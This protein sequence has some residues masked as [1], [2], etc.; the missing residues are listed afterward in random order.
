MHAVTQANGQ[1]YHYDTY[2]N[3]IQRGSDTVD[4]DVFN[5]PTRIGNHHFTYGPDRA[6]YKQVGPTG[7]T[8]YIGNYEEVI[9]T[10]GTEQR[11]TIDGFYLHTR[12]VSSGTITT[13][14]LHQ[15]HLGS[16]EAMTDSSGDYIQRMRFNA[17]GERQQ[18]DGL[19][20]D[21]TA[22]NPLHF[23]T[24]RGYTGHEMLDGL[25]L[26]HMNGRVYDPVLGRFMTADI[27]VQAPYNTQSY[28]RYSYVL[29]NPLSRI[30]PSGYKSERPQSDGDVVPDPT[31][32]INGQKHT[33]T[34]QGDGETKAGDKVQLFTVKD[35][36][37]NE[38]MYM[39]GGD[40]STQ[41]TGVGGSNFGNQSNPFAVNDIANGTQVAGLGA[42][43][44]FLLNN[45]KKA[46]DLLGKGRAAASKNLANKALKNTKNV[47]NKILSNREAGKA[48]QWPKGQGSAKQ[49][50]EMAENLSVSD[51]TK[52]INRGLNKETVKHLRSQYQ[53]ALE[54]GGKKLQNEQLLPRK[55]LMDKIL[56]LWPK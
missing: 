30:D 38:Q 33:L 27:L 46:F 47:K 31:I 53:K 39:I 25:S 50:K 26:V 32:E 11:T 21:P 56:E 55:Q 8:Y 14:Y 10:A 44:V 37:G 48:I 6:R 12:Q 9:T 17:W 24:T 1:S 16:N 36:D 5:K 22:G 29:N 40:G 20:G 35:A 52:M 54:Q 34:G 23:P 45:A 49:T 18:A 3:M 28:N 42:G 4:Y 43:F 41:I 7:T 51:V 13:T 15:D 2:G 19:I